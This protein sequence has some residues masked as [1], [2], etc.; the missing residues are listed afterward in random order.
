[1]GLVARLGGALIAV[2][3]PAALVRHAGALARYGADRVV[4]LDHPALQSYTAEAAAEAVAHLVRERTPWA[5]LLC[6]SERGRDWGPRL[7]ARLGLGLTG[8]AGGLELDGDGRMVALK[9]AFG[10]NIVAPILSKTYPQ[11]AT[12]RQGLIELTDPVNSRAPE[13]ET[14]RPSLGQPLTRLLISRS[15]LDSSIT[16]LEGAEVV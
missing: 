14:V 2:G 11:M 16:P 9:P 1:D 10:G 4:V 6:A 7:A 12:V 5:L 15:E 3:F 8:D 13:I